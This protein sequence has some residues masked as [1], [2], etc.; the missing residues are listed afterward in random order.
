MSTYTT[1]EIAKLC[2]VT[3]RT[4]QY[5]DTRGILVPSG[6]SEGG[7]RLYSD[8]DVKRL[9]IICFLRE[10][11]L[12]IDSISQ[13]LSEDDPGSVVSLLLDQQE[14]ALRKEIGEREAQLEKLEDL[15]TGLKSIESFSVESIGDIA[16][17]LENKKKLKRLRVFIILTALPLAVLQLSAI[18]LW[19]AKGIWQL[20]PIWLIV[21]VPYAVLLSRW[22]FRKMAYICPACHTVFQPSFRESFWARHTPTARR[23]TCPGCGHRGYC[24]EVAA[25]TEAGSHA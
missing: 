9:K 15:R 8:E 19:I 6:L 10:L 18:I 21:A 24:V 25:E 4:V 20:F 22:Y 16:L 23:L 1:G 2:G 17:I 13:L 14:A 11:G 12:P 3:V 5:Y 7:R